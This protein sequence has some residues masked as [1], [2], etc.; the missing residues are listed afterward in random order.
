MWYFTGLVNWFWRS[1]RIS[2]KGCGT[3]LE[4]VENAPCCF[5]QFQQFP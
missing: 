4:L 3:L 5:P 2:R 1:L